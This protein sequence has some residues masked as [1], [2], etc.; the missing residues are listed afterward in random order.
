MANANQLI[1]ELIGQQGL[2]PTAAVAKHLIAQGFSEAAARKAIQ[3]VQDP[4]HKLSGI[5]LPNRQRIVYLKHEYRTQTFW[6]QLFTVLTETESIYGIALAGMQACGGSIPQEHFARI[7][8]APKRL[9]GQVSSERVLS[10]LCSVGLLEIVTYDHLGPVVQF[11]DRTG[12]PVQPYSRLR[13]RLTAEAVLVTTLANWMRK[14]GLASYGKV[15]IREA[16]TLPDYGSYS[17]DLTAPTYLRPLTNKTKTKVDPGFITADI[18]LGEEITEVQARYFIRKATNVAARP[19]MRPSLSF[20][21]ATRFHADAW[22]AGRASGF[23]FT[24]PAL[25]F[26]DEVGNALVELVNVLSKAGASASTNPETIGDLFAKLGRIEGAAANLR[27]P[28]FEMIVGHSVRKVEGGSIDIGV[29]AVTRQGMAEIDVLLVKGTDEVRVYECKGYSASNQVTGGEID[30][31]LGTSIP[32]IYQWLREQ[33][34][35]QGSDIGFEFWTSGSFS[36]EAIALL[37]RHARQT[38]K[39]AIGWRDGPQVE[40]YV[41]RTRNGR[42]VDVFREHYRNHPLTFR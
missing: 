9:K 26:G 27:G 13:A 16:D 7:S 32:R 29:N 28:L 38:R 6:D 8:G 42:L 33:I 5:V 19:T 34:R 15:T 37:E 25:L 20:L 11:A 18:L 30:R 31:W 24:T 2:Q 35:F 4:I 14:N 23:V 3:R 21:L 41:T 12:L 40:E 1:A 10:V 22:A 36:P 17:W 39:Y